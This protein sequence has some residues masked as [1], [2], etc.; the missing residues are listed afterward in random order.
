M[1]FVSKLEIWILIHFYLFYT[2]FFGTLQIQP[3]HFISGNAIRH[4]L[5][6]AT[7]SLYACKS[8]SLVPTDPPLP[9]LSKIPSLSFQGGGEIL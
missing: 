4:S 8:D 2:V 9:H 3:I 6:V 5:N 7:L 1:H